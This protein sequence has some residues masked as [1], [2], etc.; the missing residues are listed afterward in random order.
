MA[1]ATA[2]VGKATVRRQDEFIERSVETL[3]AE[4]RFYANAMIGVDVTGYYCKGD[5]AQAW[6][7]AGVVRGEQGN[8]VLP[9]GTAGDGTLELDVHQP[10]RFELAVAS[11]AVTDIGKPVYASYDQTGTLDPSALT[12]ANLV[13]FVVDVVASGIALV[14]P[15]YDGVAANARL[16]AARFLGATG[17]QTVYKTD[18]GKTIFLPNTAAYTVTLPA[19]ADCPAGSRLTFVKTTSDAFAATLDGN[20]AETIDGATTLATLDA[21][22]DTAILVST[23]SAWVVLARDIA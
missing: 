18:L 3:A 23:G 22:Y 17:A 20:A 6:A 13:G 2:R 11:V 4:T 7:F 12:Y 1:N 15:C 10:F 8:P 5:D 14:E 9:A 16:M 19:V 21:Q